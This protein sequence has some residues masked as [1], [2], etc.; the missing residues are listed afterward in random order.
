MVG[1]VTEERDRPQLNVRD[2]RG[3][4][5]KRLV[6]D[7]AHPLNLESLYAHHIQSLIVEGGAKT[8]ALLI[9]LKVLLPEFHIFAVIRNALVPGRQRSSP[10]RPEAVSPPYS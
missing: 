4:A 5:P 10:R 9:N 1:R 7:H 6:I 8:L 2:W 3:P